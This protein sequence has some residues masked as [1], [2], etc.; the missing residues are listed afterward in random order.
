MSTIIN[1]LTGRV[2]KVGKVTYRKVMK[3]KSNINDL[4][5][6]TKKQDSQKREIKKK[7][8]ERL[9]KVDIADLLYSSKKHDKQKREEKK[10]IQD[11]LAKVDITDLLYTARKHISDVN[12]E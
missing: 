2:I 12:A 1:P 9:A 8:L 3:L 4:L 7:E 10:K 6:V 5:Q 11:R